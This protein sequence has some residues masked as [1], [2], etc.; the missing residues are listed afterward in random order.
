MTNV[1][2]FLQELYEVLSSMTKSKDDINTAMYDIIA[3]MEQYDIISESDLKKTL[4][5]DTLID[6]I[7]E[8]YLSEDYDMD[9]FEDDEE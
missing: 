6:D 8:E 5:D 3:S 4:G 9:D 2:S 1:S 7:L